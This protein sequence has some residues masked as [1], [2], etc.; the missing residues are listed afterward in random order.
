M[1]ELS[2]H[3]WYV[4]CQF[5][6]EFTSNPR[7][8]HRLFEAFVRAAVRYRELRSGA[9]D[10][11]AR[12]PGH[13]VLPD[14]GNGPDSDP[15]GDSGADPGIDSGAGDAAGAASGRADLAQPVH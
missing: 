11:V 3:P 6:P 4:G 5:H 13:A 1:V 9:Q 7:D 12:K 8:G 14:A 2:G 10:G 15:D